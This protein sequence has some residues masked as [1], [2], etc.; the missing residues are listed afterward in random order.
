MTVLLAAAAALGM[1]PAHPWIAAALGGLAL[2]RLVVLVR[3][4]G[5][6]RAQQSQPGPSGRPD[7][8]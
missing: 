3:Q 7:G 8:P 6:G 4:W 1:A 5:L 2:L